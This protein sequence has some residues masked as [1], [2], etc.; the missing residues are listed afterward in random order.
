MK[1]EIEKNE[2]LEITHKGSMRK[3]ILSVDDVDDI[4][5]NAIST[6]REATKDEIEWCERCQEKVNK[7]HSC[8]NNLKKQIKEIIKDNDK[9]NQCG[10]SA[11]NIFKTLMLSA[12]NK[13]LTYGE[14]EENINALLINGECYE[15]KPKMYR[16]LE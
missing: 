10:I 4:H 12:C 15:N 1:I 8:F 16:W 14:V 2:E 9:D 13:N 7:Y 6:T 5:V 3:V 11:D